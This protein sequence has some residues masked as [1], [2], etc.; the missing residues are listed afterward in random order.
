MQIGTRR[1]PRQPHSRSL[2][3]Q[4]FIIGQC[5]GAMWG[6]DRFESAPRRMDERLSRRAAHGWQR[7][8]DLAQL[9]LD[10]F[11]IETRNR[12][13]MRTRSQLFGLTGSEVPDL[14]PR[15][16]IGGDDSSLPWGD[17]PSLTIAETHR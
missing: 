6:F 4:G 11:I 17:P 7:V 14:G 1:D 5:Y 8:G 13:I 3:C 12:L 15:G 10:R 2:A 16:V 9:P